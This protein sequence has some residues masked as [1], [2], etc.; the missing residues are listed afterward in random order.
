MTAPNT[1]KPDGTDFSNLVMLGTQDDETC[2][3]ISDGLR[4]PEEL[5]I[6]QEKS[7]PSLATT[8]AASSDLVG[9]D[10]HLIGGVFAPH[11]NVKPP[12]TLEEV[13]G[14]EALEEKTVPEDSKEPELAQGSEETEKPEEQEEKITVDDDMKIGG[15]FAPHINVKPPTFD[16]GKLEA[17]IAVGGSHESQTMP[18]GKKAED[19][20]MTLGGVLEPQINVKPPTFTESKS[21]DELKIGGI[22]RIASPF[23]MAMLPSRTVHTTSLQ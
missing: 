19:S 8:T 9:F 5:P 18:N 11:I 16:I 6:V 4:T 13:K 15:V 7:L 22:L 10:S 2:Y 12:T 23:R 20:D 21:E 17:D 3:P 1:S 14:L